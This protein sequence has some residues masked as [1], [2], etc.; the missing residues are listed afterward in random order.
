V[1]E[2]DPNVEFGEPDR[3]VEDVP[4]LPLNGGRPSPVAGEP[5]PDER[6][7]MPVVWPN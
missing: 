2:I 1:E 6:A 5:I 3:P 7:L 4:E